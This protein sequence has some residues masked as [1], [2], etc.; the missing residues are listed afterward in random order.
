MSAVTADRVT[1][2]TD[3]P[4]LRKKRRPFGLYLMGAFTIGMII[5]LASPVFLMIL[6]GFN[7]IAGERQVPKF[8]CCTLNWWKNILAVP[9]LNERCRPH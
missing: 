7:N 2:A 8:T 1:S 9:A 5:Y 6:Y 3:L 4:P